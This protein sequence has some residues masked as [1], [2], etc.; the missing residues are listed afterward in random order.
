[1]KKNTFKRALSVFLM[2]AVLLPTLAFSAFA[3]DG[4]ETAAT[5]VTYY[6]YNANT[7]TSETD[8]VSRRNQANAVFH[9]RLKLYASDSKY[10]K[11]DDDGNKQELEAIT[12]FE[13]NE[14]LLPMSGGLGDDENIYWVKTAAFP[15]SSTKS[16]KSANDSMSTKNF[17]SSNGY[18]GG[19]AVYLY[20]ANSA[21][22]PTD[23]TSGSVAFEAKVRFDDYNADRY[24]LTPYIYDSTDKK[25]TT[26]YMNFITF[27]TDGKIQVRTKV[28]TDN[29]VFVDLGSYET[30]KWYD[31]KFVYHFSSI[32]DGS[33][34][35]NDYFDVYLNGQLK[36]KN[37]TP[38][39]N[40]SSL[41]TGM[42]LM[43]VSQPAATDSEI[44]SN[45]FLYSASATKLAETNVIVDETLMDETYTAY[46][47][48]SMISRNNTTTGRMGQSKVLDTNVTGM[49]YAGGYDVSKNWEGYDANTYV[50]TI[51]SVKEETASAGDR[52]IYTDKLATSLG[53]PV[54]DD[55]SFEIKLR[56][57]DANA[58]RYVFRLLNSQKNFNAG[59]NSYTISFL[60]NGNITATHLEG[61]N[62][63]SDKI[64]TWNINEW[65]TVKMV[66]HYSDNLYDVYINGEKVAENLYCAMDMNDIYRFVFLQQLPTE[67]L[68]ADDYIVS[69]VESIKVNYDFLSEF[70]SPESKIEVGGF[71]VDGASTT[72]LSDGNYKVSMKVFNN[73]AS[74]NKT[75]NLVLA[76]YDGEK[77]VNVDFNK[78]TSVYPTN[79]TVEPSINVSM[80]DGKSY[81]LKVFLWEDGILK[82]VSSIALPEALTSSND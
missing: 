48:D 68:G 30:G 57:E 8:N 15:S 16:I 55:V 29:K 10:W 27:G 76:L 28:G 53:S 26:N 36:V 59:N 20:D 80:E 12:T 78:V 11:T 13:G 18:T 46:V 9:G 33:E 3:A 67:N 62:E 24:V 50:Y 74:A 52:Y 51:Q 64:A 39:S 32:K 45:S 2:A 60:E 25:Y 56:F 21:M 42:N 6:S 31:V 38:H 1:M 47:N 34:T 5:D 23:F 73:D 77:L 71:T 35:T 61:V 44:Y 14:G 54:A 65:Y 69:F 37:A 81:T 41:I 72:A 22:K 70:V 75:Y 63:V 58:P 66:M 82:P 19:N 79:K 7:A 4:D 49:T 43:V 17:N 40:I